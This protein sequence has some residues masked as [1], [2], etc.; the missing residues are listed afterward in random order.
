[1]PIALENLPP[2]DEL[3]RRSAAHVGELVSERWH[4]DS[5][6]GV[7][8]MASVY[9]ATHRNGK[10]V[11]IK[12]L[13]PELSTDAG[14]RQRFIDEG[15]V[16]NR[17]KHAGT[18]SVL[19][20]GETAEGVVFLVMDL[21]QG[22]TL[23][24]RLRKRAVLDAREAL[25]IGGGLLDVLAAAHDEGI[26]HRDIKPANIFI[27]HDGMVRLL[28]F[29]IARLIARPRT[30]Q[31]GVMMGTPAFMAPEQA[32]G[33]WEQVDGRTDLWAVGATLFMALTGRLVHA[34]E[35][36]N[37]ELLA[38]MTRPAISLGAVVPGT[39][40]RLVDLVDR[41]L[42]FEQSERWPDARMMQTALRAAQ[43][44]IEPQL[45]GLAPTEEGPTAVSVVRRVVWSPKARLLPRGMWIAKTRSWYIPSMETVSDRFSTPPKHSK[46][47]PRGRRRGI[48]AGAAA[49]A[50]AFVGR[51][52][53]PAPTRVDPPSA[54]API[55]TVQP[56]RGVDPS[57]LA[58][59]NAQDSESEAP[60][61]SVAPSTNSKL[62]RAW[63]H[64]TDTEVGESKVE[65][66]PAESAIPLGFGRAPTSETDPLSRRN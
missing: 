26:V 40:K 57:T 23:E 55:A 19:D 30:T 49:F 42:A 14:V 61:S 13:H 38:A 5:L 7:G 65:T 64:A 39:P 47:V 6:I 21:L 52:G 44:E 24:E 20:D 60:T 11:A 59:A 32:R 58:I 10:R 34:A 1:M 2:D 37:E 56:N 22:E 36:V 28:D 33:H 66:R 25:A 15:Y 27:T 45:A 51:T 63:Q 31:Q 12:M 41:A 43:A 9:A 3:L 8:G 48:L 50:L 54:P 17:V 35:T 46:R 16:A 53:H 62:R 29:G 4:L 18:V